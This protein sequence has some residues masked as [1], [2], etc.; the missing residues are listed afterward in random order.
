M[1]Y[2]INLLTCGNTF[3][4]EKTK[5]NQKSFNFV[6][7]KKRALLMPHSGILKFFCC[8]FVI[9]NYFWIISITHKK[10]FLKQKLSKNYINSFKPL[11]CRY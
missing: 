11:Y 2:Y 10:T 3:M 6:P 8:C 9:G 5:D 4:F 7:L 1:L